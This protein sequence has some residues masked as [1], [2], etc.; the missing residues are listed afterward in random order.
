MLQEA[1]RAGHLH[2]C[3]G[4]AGR[5]VEQ[6]S[7]LAG[8]SLLQAQGLPCLRRWQPCMHS[9]ARPCPAIEHDTRLRLGPA[10]PKL[11]AAEGPASMH[12][13]MMQR[14]PSPA[15]ETKVALVQR[16]CGYALRPTLR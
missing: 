14:T 15:A 9:H 5:L 7:P 16:S 11:P 10:A 2:A 13:T 12:L 8:V 4:Y 6:R 1:I 3:L